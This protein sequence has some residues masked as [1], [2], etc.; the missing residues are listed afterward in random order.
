MGVSGP[1]PVSRPEVALARILLLDGH[2][3]AAVVFVRSLGRAGHHMAVGSAEGMFA[4]SALSR[5]CRERWPYPPAGEDV[6]RF[7]DALHTF[8]DA[9]PHDLVVP[10]TDATVGPLAM[11]AAEFAGQTRLAVGPAEACLLAA[12]KERT[13]ALARELG[14]AIP[15]SILIRTREDLEQVRGWPYPVVVK[16]RFSQRWVGKRAVSGLVSYAYSWADLGEQV[17]KHLANA[18][19]VLVQQFVAGTGIGFSCLVADHGI[20]LPFAWQRMREKDPRG[21]GSSTRRSIPLEAAVRQPSEA[22]LRRI[23]FQGLAMVEYKRRPD[24][25]Q[26]VLMEVNGRPWGSL[27]LPVHCGID[28]PRVLATWFLEG[29]LPPGKIDYKTG[30]TCRWLAADL[31]HLENVWQGRPPGWPAPFPNFW[32]TLLRVAVPWYPGLR[33]DESLTDPRPGLAEVGRWFRR[34]LGGKA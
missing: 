1:A 5:Y 33:Y 6:A 28:Y 11:H 14:I 22:L 7:L 18:G 10:L 20:Y 31:V 29:R 34:H 15:E 8:L 32:S 4:P 3:Q 9:H 16:D 13:L 21:S 19:D 17:Q 24:T 23:G 25:G 26:L 27:A 12:D 2:C 30:I